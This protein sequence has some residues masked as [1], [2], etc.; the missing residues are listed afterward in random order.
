MGGG[1]AQIGQNH[2]RKFQ[3]AYKVKIASEAVRRSIEMNWLH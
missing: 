1:K 2:P 3:A